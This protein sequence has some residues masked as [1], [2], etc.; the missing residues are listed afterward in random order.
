VVAELDASSRQFSLKRS[1]F[2]GPDAHDHSDLGGETAGDFT[3]ATAE[4]S[5][6]LEPALS[7]VKSLMPAKS[8]ST[9]GKT[10]NV[11]RNAAADARAN[12]N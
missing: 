8:V 11:R 5:P 6:I 4:A 3:F 9:W 1:D 12:L 7:H 2:L 10:R